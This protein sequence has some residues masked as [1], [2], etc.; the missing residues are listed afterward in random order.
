MKDLSVTKAEWESSRIDSVLDVEKLEPDD[1]ESYVRDFLLPNL[2]QSYNHVKEYISNNTKRNI[3]TIKKQLADLIANQDVVRISTSEDSESSNISRF[4]ASYMIHESL[5][6][7]YLFS[8]VM[9]SKVPPS[10]SNTRTLFTLGKLSKDIC[11]LQ[12][13]IKESIEQ[14]ARSCCLKI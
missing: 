8:S 3:Y 14:Q 5:N 9:R 13:E 2:Q 1:M 10:D 6:D 7:I 4:G 12:K 11:T